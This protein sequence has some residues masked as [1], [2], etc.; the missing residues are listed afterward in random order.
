MRIC[1]LGAT[2]SVGSNFLEVVRSSNEHSIATLAAASNLNKL[3]EQA[4][5]FEPNKLLVADEIGHEKLQR[6]IGNNSGYFDG[7][8]LVGE[9]GMRQAIED[10][11]TDCVV[12]ALSGTNGLVASI[13]TA[14]AGKKLFLANKESLVAGGDF[15]SQLC[16]ESN[17]EII[18]LDSEHN[19]IIRCLPQTY[20]AGDDLY[21]HG[22]K[23]LWLTASGGP[24]LNKSMQE[25]Q[26]AKAEDACKHPTWSMG[27][28][29][30][31]DSAT[32]MN[33]GFEIIEACHI[34]SIDQ[35]DVEVIIH[36]QSIVHCMVEYADGSIIAQFSKPDM[37]ITIHQALNY[38]H[39]TP[40]DL[41]PLNPFDMGNL[42]FEKPDS[43]KF[44][45][46]QLARDAHNI[47]GIVPLVL[48]VSDD[49]AVAA[50]LEN[51]ISFM[52]ISKVIGQATAK[53]S[54]EYS[55]AKRQEMPHDIE[56]IKKLVQE[57]SAEVLDI[58]SQI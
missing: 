46:L 24:F 48:S 2:G 55:I 20:K 5:E 6:L 34:F 38:P 36:P 41:E 54:Q 23:K 40:L 56:E 14:Q 32:M 31:I 45:C 13:L 8:L 25:I 18:P 53:H 52:D 39:Y 7:D 29:I 35:K 49:H 44:S 47:G 21:Q 58:I 33:K 43:Q 51:K 37:R 30:S 42:G 16:A 28:K 12:N 3:L 15:I 1:L 4:R 17:S 27:N 10:H 50:F 57:I 26:N 22:V 19:A 9:T 11:D